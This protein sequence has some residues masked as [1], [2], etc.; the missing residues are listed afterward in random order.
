MVDTNILFDSRVKGKYL[1]SSLDEWYYFCPTPTFNILPKQIPQPP[2][3]PQGFVTAIVATAKLPNCS[4]LDNEKV[5][6]L[7]G[8][9]ALATAAAPAL[10]AVAEAAGAKLS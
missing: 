7:I 3:Q 1:Q 6:M 10:A 5:A 4:V 9:P 2:N 8:S